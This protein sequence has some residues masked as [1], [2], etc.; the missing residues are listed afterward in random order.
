MSANNASNQS[1]HAVISSKMPIR[2]RARESTRA[3]ATSRFSEYLPHRGEAR[4][5]HRQHTLSKSAR[6]AVVPPA[7]AWQKFL[8]QKY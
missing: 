4:R 2:D 5:A 6:F 7:R 1:L 8:V 3:V